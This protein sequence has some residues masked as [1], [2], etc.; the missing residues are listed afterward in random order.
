MAPGR[1]FNIHVI[2]CLVLGLCL[3]AFSTSGCLHSRARRAQSAKVA[4]DLAEAE[5]LLDRA[6]SRGRKKRR[7][8]A[9]VELL[10]V[11]AE[12]L[13]LVE[14]LF[15][16]ALAV[17]TREDERVAEALAWHE[18]ALALSLPSDSVYEMLEER[19]AELQAVQS[20]REA[21]FERAEEALVRAG[22]TCEGED[23]DSELRDLVSLAYLAD[24]PPPAAL[25]RRLADTCFAA[26]RYDQASR[27]AE[28][29]R[30]LETWHYVPPQT[31]DSLLR[32]AV[33]LHRMGVRGP[34]VAAVQVPEP[35][36]EVEEE[37]P[38]PART[39]RTAARA[40]PPRQ[41]ARR[42]PRPR[43]EAAPVESSSSEESSTEGPNGSD[44][45]LEEAEPEPPPSAEVRNALARARRLHEAGHSHAALVFLDRSLPRLA[46]HVEHPLLLRQRE[47]WTSL[48]DDLIRG[49]FSRAEGALAA[50]RPDEA[51]EFYERILELE[52]GH[53]VSQDRLRRIE[54][55]RLLRER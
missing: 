20:E 6:S 11:R 36:P 18:A 33:S 54:Q 35:E 8:E 50:Q 27:L 25:A 7:E 16:A 10:K 40:R 24:R 23:L 2:P 49:Y 39:R 15:S 32:L 30:R 51:A 38:S 53:T 45:G 13:A 26:Q 1:T 47:Q 4:G 9:E 48:R 44:T 12:R 55:L 37:I 22:R 17:E 5:L 34:L 21:D 52:P 31:S 46:D 3:L 42:A 19:V 41:Q 28:R 43:P 14:R 29:A